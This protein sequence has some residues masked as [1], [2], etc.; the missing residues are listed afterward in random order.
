MK[1]SKSSSIKTELLD[2]FKRN[3]IFVLAAEKL[4]KITDFFGQRVDSEIREVL[5]KLK[6][7]LQSHEQKVSKNLALIDTTKDELN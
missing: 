7:E 3:E 2:N 5:D 1:Q 6:S 4:R